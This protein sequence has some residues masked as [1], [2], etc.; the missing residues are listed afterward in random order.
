MQRDRDMLVGQLVPAEATDWSAEATVAQV[1]GEETS[2]TNRYLR[3]KAYDVALGTIGWYLYKTLQN[4]CLGKSCS[5]C[6]CFV[7]FMCFLGPNS[8]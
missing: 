3:Y 5:T 6:F 7:I 2:E 1:V 8:A 4:R